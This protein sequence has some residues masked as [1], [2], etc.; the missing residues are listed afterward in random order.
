MS[1][2]LMIV[3]E[4]NHWLNAIELQNGII[5][6]TIRLQRDQGWVDNW[7]ESEEKTSSC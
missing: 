5:K 3:F 4:N 1:C 2:H 7:T 6:C